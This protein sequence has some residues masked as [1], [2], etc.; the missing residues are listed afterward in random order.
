MQAGFSHQFSIYKGFYGS[1]EIFTSNGINVSLCEEM[2]M[3]V[4]LTMTQTISNHPVCHRKMMTMMMT[5]MTRY[6]GFSEF[7]F[8]IFDTT[9]LWLAWVIGITSPL[10]LQVSK[11]LNSSCTLQELT[12]T[13]SV[14]NTDLL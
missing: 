12:S 3:M 5:K 1:V 11:V 7:D 10:I 13:L 2:R 9:D 14:L 6:S 4:M 8:F